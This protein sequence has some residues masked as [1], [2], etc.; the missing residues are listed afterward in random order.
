MSIDRWF[1][2]AMCFT[3][4]ASIQYAP[5]GFLVAPRALA[6]ARFFSAPCAPCAPAPLPT[7]V[8]ALA[9]DSRPRHD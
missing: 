2:P 4:L 8:S 7:L 6:R 1:K 5:L 9:G 3:A